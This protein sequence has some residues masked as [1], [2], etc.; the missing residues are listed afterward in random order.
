MDIAFFS[1]MLKSL[2]NRQDVIRNTAQYCWANKAIADDILRM[3]EKEF[4]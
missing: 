4:G 3:M 2:D 1:E